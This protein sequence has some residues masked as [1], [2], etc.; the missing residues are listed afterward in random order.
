L[1]PINNSDTAWLIVSDFN[2]DNGRFYEDLREDVLNP[3]VNNW[4]FE[5]ISSKHVGTE[6]NVDEAL[7]TE[8]VGDG[9]TT[10]SPTN[11]GHVGGYINQW[12]NGGFVGS[13]LF[14]DF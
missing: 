9:N 2:Q 14:S 10:Q 8:D 6:E 3:D 7:G 13:Q 12:I 4:N 11:G 5:F 1:I